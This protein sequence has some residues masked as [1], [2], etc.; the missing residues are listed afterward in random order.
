MKD[1]CE[2]LLVYWLVGMALVFPEATTHDVNPF[3]VQTSSPEPCYSE[4]GS[5]RYC[6]PE[7]VNAAF[8]QEVSVSSTCGRRSCEQTHL[9]DLNSAQNL[10]CWQSEMLRTIPYN[11]TLT[12]SLGKKFE[13]TY[14]SLNFCSEKPDSMAIYKSMDYGRSW[15]PFQFY[16]SQCRRVYD[17]LNRAEITKLNEQEPLCM[18][19]PNSADTSNAILVFSTLDGRPSRTNFIS[20]PVLQDWVTVT[21]IRVTFHR[22]KM[23]K[24]VREPA[25]FY[26]V[27]DFQVGG[28]CKCNGHA[29]RCLRDKDGKMVCDCKHNTEGPECD[30]CKP[31]HYDRPW[32]R[33]TPKE[34]NECLPCNCNLHAR[35]CRFNMELYKLSGR[36]SGGVCMNCRHN[37]AGRHCHYCKEGYYRDMSRPI[38]HRKACIACD[39]H[40]VGAAGKTCNQTSGQCQCKDGVTG[41]TCNRCAK[42]YQQSRSPVAPC[43]KIPT[44]NP[45]AMV[46]STEGP[47]DCESYCKPAKGNLKINTK[48]Y[49]KK[50]YAVLVSVL[51]METVGD[52]AKFSISLVSVYKS[53]EPLKRGENALWV[54]M[55]DLACKCPRIHMGKRFLILGS[56]GGGASAERAGLVADKNSLVIQWRDIWTRRLRKFQ[57]RE[58]KGKCSAAEHNHE[59]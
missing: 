25:Y 28:R 49:C 36:K 56:G 10:T 17:R 39:C 3:S 15:T 14:I 43:I 2:P 47:A 37:T 12:L 45:T 51:D 1:F 58:K 27:S 41:L 34:A 33:A 23:I 21:D 29:H 55:K 18:E 22:P 31:F 6:I 53:R 7:F 46:S 9:T 20:S 11:V 13:I 16:S 30:R 48:K 42:G 59:V 19:L 57:R 5:A 26:A 8:G 40:P 4:S 24:D 44:I 50:D 32:Q 52:W 35:R 38:T 54:H